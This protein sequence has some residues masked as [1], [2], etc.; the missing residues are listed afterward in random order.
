MLPT[1]WPS[2]PPPR[3]RN[4]Q[5]EIAASALT[6]HEQIGVGSFKRVCRATLAAPTACVV[7]ALRVR[8]ADM[9][10]EVRVLMVLGKHPR[11]FETFESQK[12]GHLSKKGHCS[13]VACLLFGPMRPQSRDG[14]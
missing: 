1:G 4:Q 8:A 5:A 13:T 3:R 6:L 10:A 9:A 14:E 12:L 7:A 2:K 11:S